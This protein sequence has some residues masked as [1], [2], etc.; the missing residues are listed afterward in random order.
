VRD[1]L[2]DVVAME[3]VGS[4]SVPGLSGKPTI[5]VAAGVPTLTLDSTARQQMEGLGYFY[6]GDLG[7]RQH[8]FRK[9]IGVPWEFI[10]HVVEHDG[11]MWQDFLRSVTICA[12]VRT[13]PSDT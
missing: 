10:V 8:V 3:H 13:R 4:T 9:G 12:R 5:D 1:A 11:Q 6:G 7:L 2:G